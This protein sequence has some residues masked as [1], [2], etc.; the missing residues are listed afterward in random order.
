MGEGN[1]RVL[2]EA[3]RILKSGHP[4]ADDC[5][6][7]ADAMLHALGYHA[8]TGAARAAAV[9]LLASGVYVDDL[10]PIPSTDA[11]GLH[12]LGGVADPA[13]LG[14]IGT[15]VPKA[16]LAGSGPTLRAALEA[17]LGEAVEYL[18]QIDPSGDGTADNAPSHAHERVPQPDWD[19][20]HNRMNGGQTALEPQSDRIAVVAFGTGNTYTL[21]AELVLRRPPDAAG[22][23]HRRVPSSLGCA[24]GPTRDDATLGAIMELVERDAVARWWLAGVRGRPVHGK[25]LEQADIDSIVCGARRQG[26]TRR[27]WFV[28]ITSPLDLPVVTALSLNADGSGFAFGLGAHPDPERAVQKAFNELCQTEVAGPLVDAKERT[29]GPDSLNEGDRLN[30]AR[31]NWPDAGS[32]SRLVPQGPPRHPPP[33]PD[34]RS[35]GR[36]LEAVAEHLGRHSVTVYLADLTRSQFD[37]PVVWAGSANLIPFPCNPTHGPPVSTETLEI[38]HNARPPV[39]LM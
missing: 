34:D 10:F 27:T 23:S 36:L 35:A 25:V 13:A 20:L 29:L 28:D 14:A 3:A 7:R 30:R 24:A 17:C 33:L 37:I 2:R 9:R 1:A 16:S 21:P 4:A 15:G 19:L 31:H 32:D 11:P 5:G 18:S 22:H 12:I 39:R 38:P 26:S 8:L 6:R